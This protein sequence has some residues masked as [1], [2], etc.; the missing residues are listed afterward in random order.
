MVDPAALSMLPAVLLVNA[1]AALLPEEAWTL[2]QDV[3]L[4]EAESGH[5]IAAC[6]SGVVASM[7]LQSR[8]PLVDELRGLPVHRK[9]TEATPLL[10]RPWHVRRSRDAALACDLSLLTS[11][12]GGTLLPMEVT[13]FG[14][15]PIR[16]AQVA[17]VYPGS[18][19]D[20]EGGPIVVEADAVVRPGAILI[21]PCFVGKHATILERATIRPNTAIGPW[22][23]VNGEVGGTIFQGYA[24]KAHDGYLGDSFVG[25][26]ANLGAGTTNSNLLNTY[27]EIIT[28]AAPDAPNE[29]TG[30]QFLGATIGDHVKT[31]ICTRLMTGCV[32]HLGGMFAQTAAVSGAVRPFTW[33]TDAGQR[34][35]RL[36]KFMEV[37]HAAMKRR[38]IVPGPAYLARVKE[39]HA[40][41]AAAAPGSQT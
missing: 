28:K 39:L 26:W 6:V 40:A 31:A 19:F 30:E 38:G 8:K 29:R 20:A 16:V 22:C 4:I 35:F 11:H 9:I 3:A 10:S 15:H 36:D 13:A 1:R 17:K 14:T 23:K 7:I 24:N 37:M 27:G 32:L 21:G 34:A 41:A 18:V 5:T 12:P 2:P 25:E 33:A